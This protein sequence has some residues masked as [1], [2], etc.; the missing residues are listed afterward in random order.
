MEGIL[1]IS[2]T[3]LSPKEASFLLS[4]TIFLLSKGQFRTVPPAKKILGF[5]YSC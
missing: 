1:T 5:D 4:H 2:H 3:F